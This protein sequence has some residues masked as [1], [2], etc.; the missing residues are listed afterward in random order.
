VLSES[1][2]DLERFLA[3]YGG[4]L[5]IEPILLRGSHPDFPAAVD[6]AVVAEGRG[7]RVHFTIRAPIDRELC[8]YCGKC[9]SACPEDCLSEQLVIDFSRCTLCRECERVCPVQAI[10]ISAAETRSLHI[11]AV[12]VLHGPAVDLPEERLGIFS[13]ETL[14]DL[15]A[16]VSAVEIQE[17]IGCDNRICQYAGRL[18]IGCT[19][20]R[21][22]CPSSAI[23]LGADGVAVDVRACRECGACVSVCPTGALQYERFPDR[24]FYTYFQKIHLP[25]GTTVIVGSEKVLHEFWWKY[26]TEQQGERLFFLEHPNVHAL[27]GMQLL[28]LFARGAGRIVLVDDAAS[29]SGRD[30]QQ[31]E[32]EKVNTLI[33]SLFDLSETVLFCGPKEVENYLHVENDSPLAS[34]FSDPVYNGRRPAL[35]AILEHL[36]TSSKRQIHLERKN[37]PWFATLDCDTNRCSQCL[38]CLNECKTVALAAE[39]ST[40]A[41]L[42]TPVRCIACGV[43][44]QVCPED[45]LQIDPD[46]VI[47]AEFFHYRELARGEAMVCRE[48]GKAF[49]TKKSYERVASILARRKGAESGYLEY[50]DTC[51]VARIFSGN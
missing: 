1:A 20:C 22:I 32:V 40:L 6:A 18:G 14:P 15:F 33:K 38:A 48:C 46:F 23:T 13:E 27:N 43:C 7:F 10:D 21:D 2:G 35:A 25:P 9:G 30:R 26:G 17:V 34:N 24:S 47:N 16:T 11:P 28:L 49:G 5:E 3:T 45:A 41:L 8:S 31:G 29:A 36:T 12:V 51:R 4:V 50:C 44:V 42:H 19:L 39:Q 37:L